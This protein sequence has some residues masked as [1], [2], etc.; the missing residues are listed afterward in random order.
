MTAM[1]AALEPPRLQAHE[2]VSQVVRLTTLPMVYMKVK[3]CVEDVD[4]SLVDLA[5]IIAQDPALSAQLLRIANSAFFG[6][7]AKISTVSRAANL[8]GTQ[9][10]HDLALAAS[11]AR[12]FAGIAPE[13]MD[14]Q[15]FWHDSIDCGITAR[16]LAVRCNVLDSERL[17][18]EGLLRDIGHVVLY[19]RLPGPSAEALSR[20]RAYGRPLFQVERECLGFDYAQIGSMLMREWRLPQ[21]LQESVHFHPE[22]AKAQSYPL[23]S[24]IVH[25]AA[26]F[27][28]AVSAGLDCGQ[29][30]A[31]VDPFAW[32]TTGL[33]E[34][35][36]AMLMEEAT[37]RTAE[38]VA[39]FFPDR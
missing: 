26:R 22:P 25:V 33:S 37:E 8:L 10:V 19:D 18:V 34:T 6:F 12:T 2:L 14:M 13:V 17:F 7:T 38:T 3:K 32:R 15:R 24:S 29:W 36:F 35:V 31:S 39:L 1:A 5:E 11:V 21:A 23:E 4:S 20:A 28:E 9:Q 16:I 27:T 30:A